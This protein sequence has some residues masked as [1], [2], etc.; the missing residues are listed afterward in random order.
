MEFVNPAEDFIIF[1]EDR[2]LDAARTLEAVRRRV[3]CQPG[4]PGF[5][6]PG[7]FG[8]VGGKATPQMVATMSRG[9]SDVTA[10]LVAAA[11]ATDL[12][13][14]AHDPGAGDFGGVVHENFTDVD[15][16]YSTD[17]RLCPTAK[18]MPNLS[19]GQTHALAL[20]GAGV[21][22][23]DA[24]TPLVSLGVPIHVRSTWDAE[25]KG[26]WIS[27]KAAEGEEVAALP[28]AATTEA[29]VLAL[30]RATALAVAGSGS[31]V[32]VV[33]KEVAEPGL[34][35][36]AVESRLA[37][38]LTARGLAFTQPKGEEGGLGVAIDIGDATQLN[39]AVEAIFDDLLKPN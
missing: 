29:S 10:S 38:A 30:G 12:K 18:S 34:G 15:G 17:P 2:K 23:P 21:L 11:L 26:T 5:V 36:R 37:A 19:Y 32:T 13:T 8:G 20:A 7:F 3:A 27:A 24:V 25:G 22:H 16:V 33:C 31:R 4:A 14:S 39:A 28:S 1:G 9:G 35:R 6:I